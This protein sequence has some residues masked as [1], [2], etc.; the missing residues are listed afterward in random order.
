MT[1]RQRY[2]DLFPC[3]AFRKLATASPRR[4][5]HCDRLGETFVSKAATRIFVADL[6]RACARISF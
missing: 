3:H 1:I 2:V 4:S 6:G 5:F